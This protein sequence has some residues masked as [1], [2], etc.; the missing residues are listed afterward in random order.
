MTKILPLLVFVMLFAGAGTAAAQDKGTAGSGTTGPTN[1]TP[2]VKAPTGP[3]ED[4]GSCNS[5]QG[6]K[7]L[8]R[9]CLKVKLKYTST[10]P[11]TGVCGP[12]MAKAAST[13]FVADLKGTEDAFCQGKALCAALKQTCQGTWKVLV[14]GQAAKCIDK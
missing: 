11:A 8:K 14:P 3:M 10:G 7:V 6:C 2:V 13:T 9:A 12:K 5:V 4:K 1:P